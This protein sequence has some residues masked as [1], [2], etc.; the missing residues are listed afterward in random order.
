MKRVIASFILF[1]VL[2]ASCQDDP[3]PATQFLDLKTFRVE[4]PDTWKNVPGV[5]YDSQVGRLTNDSDV[6][7]Y[8]YGWY[9]YRLQNETSATHWRTVTT[10]D[11]RPALIVRPKK[12]GQGVIGLFVEVDDL[13]RLSLTGHDIRDEATVLRLFKS[14]KF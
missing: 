9:S 14:V 6:L 8:D 5:G 1:I 10:I 12:T 13:N 3:T 11:G 2:Q 7:A 4:V